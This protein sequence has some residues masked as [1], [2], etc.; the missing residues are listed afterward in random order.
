[1]IYDVSLLSQSAQERVN[2]VQVITKQ[3]VSCAIIYI[4]GNVYLK[5]FNSAYENYI[6][7][8]CVSK[9]CD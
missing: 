3:C 9:L 7:H 1:M 5:Y 2:F 8:I 4:G 6:I